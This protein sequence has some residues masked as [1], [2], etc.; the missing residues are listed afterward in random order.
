MHA[1]NRL[2]RCSHL[3]S[4]RVIFPRAIASDDCRLLPHI[5]SLGQAL[6]LTATIARQWF[7]ICGLELAFCDLFLRVSQERQ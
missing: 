1:V 5:I 6:G 7:V 3:L 4:V 2:S